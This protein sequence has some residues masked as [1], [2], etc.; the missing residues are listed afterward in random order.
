MAVG[1]LARRRAR[2]CERARHAQD[3]RVIADVGSVRE[4]EAVASTLPPF[5][6][7]DRGILT[8]KG[9]GLGLAGDLPGAERFWGGRLVPAGA[10]VIDVS[11]EG[12]STAVIEFDIPAGQ[13]QGQELAR[14]GVAVLLII[15][16]IV[17]ALVVLGWV[18]TRITLAVESVGG[19]APVI[20]GL[21]IAGIIAAVAI[22]AFFSQRRSRSPT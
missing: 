1:S 3:F 15:G 2:E 10:R 6:E 9:P 21:V 5:R 14:H 13:G 16:A 12:F 22:P 20:G 18:I 19:Q 7:G 11:G 17:G 4:L 8:V